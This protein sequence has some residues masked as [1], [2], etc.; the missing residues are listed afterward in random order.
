MQTYKRLGPT[1]AI[2]LLMLLANV[3]A[4]AGG[5]ARGQLYSTAAV[6]KICGTAQQLVTSTE[7]DVN[8]VVQSDWAAF[9]QADAAP[10]SVVGTIPPL[11]YSPPEE[12]DVQLTSQQHVIY[13]YYGTGMRDYPQVV[14]CKMKLAE[15]LNTTIPGL[16]AVDQPCGVV[17]EQIVTDVVASLTNNEEYQVVMEPDDEVIIEDEFNLDEDETFVQGNQWT[18]GFP[19]DPYPVLYRQFVGGPIHVKASALVVPSH[20]GIIS[21]CNAFVPYL[22][23]GTPI[24]SFCEP[25]KW[26]VRYCH[27]A[28]PE[29]V[30]AA[31]TNEVDVP[32]LPGGP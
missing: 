13:D 6:N 7:L 9:V 29:Y 10:Y 32:I 14:S 3:S 28:A 15:Y 4:S 11:A 19:E 16:G 1:G 25:R 21:F 30:R 31:L 12:P 20:P 17:N 18:A 22:P 26:G 23:P 5:L 24:P 2:V 8:N 27:V